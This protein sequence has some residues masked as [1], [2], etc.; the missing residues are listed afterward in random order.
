MQDPKGR[1]DKGWVQDPEGWKDKGWEDW[2]DKGQPR[3]KDWKGWQ[4][5]ESWDPQVR[6]QWK[7]QTP[8]NQEELLDWLDKGW[9]AWP[10]EDDEKEEEVEEQDSKAKKKKSK[11]G[12]KNKMGENFQPTI[13]KDEWGWESSETA[14]AA[15]TKRLREERQ[16]EKVKEL[17]WLRLLMAQGTPVPLQENGHYDIPPINPEGEYVFSWED[18]TWRKCSD[19]V[20]GS[21][22]SKEPKRP[23]T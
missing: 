22:G 4:E 13:F 16:M 20:G 15:V 19:E 11:K 9:Q 8:Q 12:R 3:D 17:G 2:E 23:A 5:W 21:T 6:Q 1:E 10:H 14:W 7:E 18:C